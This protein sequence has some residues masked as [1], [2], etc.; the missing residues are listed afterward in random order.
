MRIGWSGSHTVLC[1]KCIS[2]TRQV[3]SIITSEQMKAPPSLHSSQTA[4]LLF[5]LIPFLCLL[6]SIWKGMVLSTDVA[7]RQCDIYTN[8]SL[9]NNIRCSLINIHKASTQSCLKSVV[10]NSRCIPELPEDSN[11][12]HRPRN[13]ATEIPIP[14][15]SCFS[16][17]HRWF[18]R[19]RSVHPQLK[20]LTMNQWLSN[21]D[22]QPPPR[23]KETGTEPSAF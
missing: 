23:P 14:Q 20:M 13:P 15:A 19:G 21:L 7:L 11:K 9:W 5:T 1:T 8:L 2:H 12:I 18:H 4:E 10:T 6:T 22:A 3:L 17:S 16:K